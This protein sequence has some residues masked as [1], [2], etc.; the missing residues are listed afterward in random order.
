MLYILTH[1]QFYADIT[2]S[3][4]LKHVTLSIIQKILKKPNFGPILGCFAPKIPKQQFFQYMFYPIFSLYTA[5]TSCKNLMHRFAIKLKTLILGTFLSKNPK[6]RF[7]PKN[8]LIQ[9]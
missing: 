5:V 9:F 2:S 7:F 3:K 6:A 4:K 1:S 8:Y